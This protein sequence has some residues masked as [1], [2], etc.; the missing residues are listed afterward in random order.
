MQRAPTISPASRTTYWRQPR[1]SISRWEPGTG[2]QPVDALQERGPLVRSPGLDELGSEV[3]V[4]RRAQG[5]L[6]RR[7]AANESVV[8]VEGL[9]PALHQPALVLR[10]PAGRQRLQEE[11]RDAGA[12]VAVENAVERGGCRRSHDTESDHAAE[13]AAAGRSPGEDG[14]SRDFP[15]P[16]AHAGGPFGRCCRVEIDPGARF[17]RLHGRRRRGVH[18]DVDAGSCSDR[19][20]G[21]LRRAR[22]GAPFRPARLAGQTPCPF[23]ERGA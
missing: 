6:E 10:R 17:G 14:R 20:G 9:E 5:R 19:R 11:H 4:G 13:V 21:F 22:H 2:V 23:T 8:S 16:E 1:R 3:A 18:R 15:R 7:V 12:G